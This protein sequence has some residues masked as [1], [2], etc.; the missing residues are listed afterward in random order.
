MLD[1]PAEGEEVL[2]RFHGQ[3]VEGA[4]QSPSAGVVVDDKEF[5]D[6]LVRSDRIYVGNAPDEILEG[7]GN[8]GHEHGVGVAERLRLRFRVEV[9]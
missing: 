1:F 2:I 8:R 9:T 4:A 7:W 5:L 6:G 3:G